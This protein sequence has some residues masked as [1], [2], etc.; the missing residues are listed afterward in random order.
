MLSQTTLIDKLVQ[1]FGKMHAAPMS[2][3]MDP[4][5]KLQHVTCTSLPAADQDE[6]SK[7]PCHSLI[8][9]LLHLAV[10]TCLDIS[11]AVQQLSQFLDTYS[12]VHLHAAIW[13]VLY[14]KGSWD[15]KLHLGGSNISLL[16][17]LDSDWVKCLDMRCSVRGYAF[18]GVIL[19]NAHKWKMV[20]ASSCEAKYIAGFEATK[21]CI[22]LCTL[23]LEIGMASTSATTILCDN[24]ATIT[25]RFTLILRWLLVTIEQ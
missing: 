12:Y 5:L 16:G 15:V 17:F 21:E 20:A 24:S 18:S 19:W 25:V 4:S 9:C 22:W 23:L 2:V 10:G 14:L 11:Y 6:L 3:P 13:V 7:F 1:M 8:G